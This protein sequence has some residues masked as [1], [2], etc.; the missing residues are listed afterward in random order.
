MMITSEDNEQ[1]MRVRLN[2]Q[3]T[4]ELQALMQAYGF[5]SPTHAVS[6]LIK[7]C[8]EQHMQTKQH[9]EANAI[10]NKDINT[11]EVRYDPQRDAQRSEARA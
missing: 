9:K 8:F 3:A 7:R 6:K 2:K 1:S 5:T 10:Q 4:H 11:C